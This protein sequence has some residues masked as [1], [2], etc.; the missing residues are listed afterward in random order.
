MKSLGGTIME[1]Q[2]TITHE[3]LALAATLH[4]PQGG[5]EQLEKNGKYPVVVICHGFVGSRIGVDRLFVKTARQLAAKGNYVLRFDY[6]GCG[7]SDGEYGSLGFDS[8]VDQTRTVLD[9]ISSCDFLDP[10]RLSLL[11][12]SLGG[13]V[14][15]M[16]AVKD[17]RV[18]RLILWSAVGYPFNDI[19]R[20]VGRQSYDVAYTK[21]TTDYAGYTLTPLFFDSLMEH[22]PFQSA[23]RFSGDVL[24]VHGTSDDVIPVDYGFLYQKIFWTR[25]EGTC[26]KEIIFQA[27]HTYSTHTHQ[28]EAIGATIRWL[29]GLESRA[30]EWVNWSI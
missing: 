29:D 4:Y 5:T 23:T 13:A 17:R 24:L 26:E 25:S 16:T 30:D 15:I 10:T 21:G 3:Q 18:K 19:V 6:G 22:Q 28:Q 12:H 27:N 1:K 2:L 20:I 8:M 14:A 11:G 9:Y 7:E